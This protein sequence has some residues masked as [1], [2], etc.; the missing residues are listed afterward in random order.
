MIPNADDNVKAGGGILVVFC[1]PLDN[2]VGHSDEN[3][4]QSKLHAC[5]IIETASPNSTT[6][7]ESTVVITHESIWKE[8]FSN[9]RRFALV[10]I[11][12]PCLVFYAFNLSRHYGLFLSRAIQAVATQRRKTIRRQRMI[13]TYHSS[14]VNS[15]NT[16]TIRPSWH[17]SPRPTSLYRY[18]STVLTEDCIWLAGIGGGGMRG[19][20]WKPYGVF[21]AW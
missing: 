8:T 18:R 9:P 2:I 16:L 17:W 19:R 5:E 1:V 20:K 12:L 11:A 13:R 3:V 21:E 15:Y 4:E 10:F 7:S 6:S 14:I